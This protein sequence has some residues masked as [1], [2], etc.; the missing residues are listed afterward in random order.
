[1]Q[2]QNP[3]QVHSFASADPAQ[4]ALINQM[5]G[6]TG[7]IGA[8]AS[9]N[10]VSGGLTPM[11]KL[12]LMQNMNPA[13]GQMGMTGVGGMNANPLMAGAAGNSKQLPSKF[14]RIN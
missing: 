8:P 13:M 6:G 14:I 10:A 3:Q 4:Q 2:Q 5:T 9:V 1:M 7:L 12:M 11:Q